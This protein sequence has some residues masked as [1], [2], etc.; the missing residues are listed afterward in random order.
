MQKSF[1]KE[2]I[3]YDYPLEALSLT[4]GKLYEFDY[5]VPISK[6]G[7]NLTFRLIENFNIMSPLRCFLSDLD[8][9][10]S[11]AP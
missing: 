3:Q 9:R 10:N 1:D 4:K 2:R 11:I 8:G 7:L 6:Q 5:Y